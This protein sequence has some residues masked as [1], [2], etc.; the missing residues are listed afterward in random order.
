MD[1]SGFIPR[2]RFEDYKE[3]YKDYIIMER[4]NGVIM[5]RM[6]SKGGPVVWGLD[7]HSALTQAWHEVG[8]DP[9]NDVMILTS[10]DPYWMG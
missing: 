2:P 10:T 5:L 1:V 9:E 3:K 4:R 7:M 6:H 8:N